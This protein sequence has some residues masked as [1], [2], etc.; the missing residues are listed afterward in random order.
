MNYLFIIEIY[1]NKKIFFFIIGIILGVIILYFSPN[2]EIKKTIKYIN[3][4]KSD[5]VKINQME[6]QNI[7]NNFPELPEKI[8]KLKNAIFNT[9]NFYKRRTEPIVN[10][11]YNERIKKEEINHNIPIENEDTEEEETN[12]FNKDNKEQIINENNFIKENKSEQLLNQNNNNNN[13]KYNPKNIFERDIFK[14]I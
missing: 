12:S 9:N 8:L 2:N 5:A 14:E 6:H 13:K 4:E 10:K 3:Y 1:K 7:I 11:K